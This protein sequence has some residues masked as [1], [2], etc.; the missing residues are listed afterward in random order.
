MNHKEFVEKYKSGRLNVF[1]H[2]T[3]ALRAI[4]EGYL[5]KKYF[6]AHTFWS[7]VWFLSLPT[8]LIML[9]LNLGIGILILFFISFLGGKA[10]KRSAIDFVLQHALEDEKFFKFA[11]EN[12]IIDVKSRNGA[13]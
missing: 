7:W 13:S 4:S 9:F 2:K 8:G 12:R 5:P 1:V 11:I 10:V 6:W 3:Y